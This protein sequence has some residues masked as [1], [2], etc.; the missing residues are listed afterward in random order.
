LTAPRPA[1]GGGGE[2]AYAAAFNSLKYGDFV[3]SARAVQECR[4]D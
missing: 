2:E 3:E 4:R 1:S